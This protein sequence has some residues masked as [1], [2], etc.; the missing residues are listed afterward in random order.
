MGGGCKFLVAAVRLSVC[1]CA[2]Y[3]GGAGKV[4]AVLQ[5]NP[6]TLIPFVEGIRSGSGQISQFIFFADFLGCF[7]FGGKKVV[8]IRLIA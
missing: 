1:P 2:C 7:V 6:S 4:K 5:T 3:K 8:K